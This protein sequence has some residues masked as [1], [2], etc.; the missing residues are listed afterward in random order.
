M[1]LTSHQTF[2]I[3]ERFVPSQYFVPPQSIPP[4]ALTANL[5][6]LPVVC[7]SQYLRG[8]LFWLGI[9]V[10]FRTRETS[11]GPDVG[12]C[13][14][15][16]CCFAGSQSVM[17]GWTTCSQMQVRLDSA[18][19]LFQQSHIISTNTRRLV[20]ARLFQHSPTS[21]ARTQDDLCRPDYFN[22]PT[23]LS[24]TQDSLCR[25]LKC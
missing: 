11:A 10:L 19:W 5:S 6:F 24:R 13:C 17:C 25:Q 15:A 18:C 23:S 4:L 16:L 14:I 20:S 22:S 3:H 1:S 9:A 12:K 7:C 21:L 2:I 8:K